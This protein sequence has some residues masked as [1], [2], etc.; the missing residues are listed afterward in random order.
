MGSETL[1]SL[2]PSGGTAKPGLLFVLVLRVVF[3]L[4]LTAVGWSVAGDESIEAGALTGHPDLIVIGS[5]GTALIV[6][7]LDLFVPRKS[8]AAISGLF[9]GLIVKEE[10]A[11]PVVAR[12]VAY[13]QRR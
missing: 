2:T 4:V 11:P 3:V 13:F 7:A 5:I 6:I 8:L 10:N 1:S 12:T 9:F